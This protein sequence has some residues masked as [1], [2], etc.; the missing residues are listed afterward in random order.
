MLK[1]AII[2]AWDPYVIINSEALVRQINTDTKNIS[3]AEP[4]QQGSYTLL[5]CARKLNEHNQA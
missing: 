5:K 1:G 2:T 3:K 4:N